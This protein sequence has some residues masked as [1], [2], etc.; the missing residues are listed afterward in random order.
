MGAIEIIKRNGEVIPLN[1]REPF[2]MVQSA[3]Q[4][5][6][7]MG[8]DNIQLT[9]VANEVLNLEK[10]DKINVFG[11]EYSIRTKASRELLSDSHYIIEATFYGVMY[12]LMKTQYRNTDIYGKST[13][14]TF[15]L[16]YSIKDFIKVLIYNVERDY[17]GLWVFDEANCP[18]TEPITLQFSK[19][20]CLQ[21]LQT[22]CKK[23]NFNLD[24]RITQTAGVRIIHIGKF[25]EVVVPPGGSA[26]FEWGK[27]AVLYK[28]KE[29]KVDDKAIIT[30]LWV[31]GGTTNI[32][33][34]YRNYSE[35]L[36]LPYPKRLN[37]YEH[38][39]E[40]GTVI[41]AN[42]QMIGIDNE[43]RRYFEDVELRDL[44]GSDE[45][46][47]QYEDIYPTRTGTITAISRDVNTFFDDTMDFDLT[48]KNEEGETKWLVAGVNA[49]INFITGKLAG[50]QFELSANEGYI[51]SEKKF[52]IIPFTDE[53]GLTIPT[54]DNE[55]FRIAPG[56]KY[57]ITDINMPDSYIDAAEE[58]LWYAGLQTFNDR[59]QP[60]AQY[61]LTLDRMYFIN[62]LPAESTYPV[63]KVG[64]YVPVRDTRFGVEKN[65][66]IQKIVR[67]LLLDHDYTL[68]LS[69]I[70]TIPIIN[71]AVIE[72]LGHRQII[73]NAR[74]KNINKI[75]GGWR[76][77]EELRNMVYD[78]DGYFDSDN[79]RP[80][81]IDTNMLTVGS[82]S[83]QFVLEDV[84]FEA[85]VN[86]LS[87]R[88]NASAGLLIHLA[89]VN[90]GVRVWSMAA[91]EFTTAE[92]GGYYLFAK[93]SKDTLNGVWH[94]STQ[95]IKFENPEDPDNYYFQVGILSSIRD[96]G[97]FRDFSTTYGYT[98]VN[99]N[100]ITTGR[101]VSSDGGCYL[102][103]D[104]NMFKIGDADS[105]IDWGV[106]V[107]GQ[108]TLKN[109]K[110]LSTSGDLS[111]IGVYRGIYYADKVYYPGDE[112]SYDNGSETCTYRYIYSTPA[113]GVNP[114]TTTHW[115][116]LA[117]GAKGD[118]GVKGDSPA[119]TYQGEYSA[120]ATYY[121]T[122]VRVD[123]VK[124]QGIYY[125]ALTT[126]GPFTGIIPTNTNYWSTMGSQFEQIATSLLLAEE[127]N[128]GGLLFRNQKLVSQNNGS[129][130][131]P[132]LT[133]DGV[134]GKIT[135][136]DGMFYG[137][138]ATPPVPIANSTAPLTLS[139]T[140]GFNFSGKLSAGSK[141][142]I[143]PYDSE[144]DGVE[145]SIINYGNITDGHYNIS[146]G[147][148]SAFL[149][150]GKY[151]SIDNVTRIHLFG[152]ARLVLKAI[153]V[154][155]Q[156]RWFVLNHNDF[157]YNYSSKVLTNTLAR[158]AMKCIGV[159]TVN[160][161]TSLVTELCTDGNT[162]TM[163]KVDEGQWKFTFATARKNTNY[164][165]VETNNN[166]PGRIQSY[167]ISKTEFYLFCGY[168]FP[169][170][171][172]EWVYLNPGTFR[173]Y[174]IEYDL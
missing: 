48:E 120:D 115:M 98:R 169:I 122:A 41:P 128:V 129:D 37:I 29:D 57:K 68:T 32:K 11:E 167:N 124:Y 150:T 143:L 117:K 67:N 49:K 91:A 69:D 21:V 112:V 154:G 146:V 125:V 172:G 144:Y 14:S 123:A 60:R 62:N 55:A 121:G 92:M 151:D 7:L 76:T 80:N 96:Y 26:F 105:W 152:C 43:D 30:R 46:S 148:G 110:L 4:T 173:F 88:F 73:E 108:L 54:K 51:H 136:R 77:T 109:V 61:Q 119:L 159:Y 127:A 171:P 44:L 50:Q 38:T 138:F 28:L 164:M 47:E 9:I 15:D 106:T 161:G 101:I 10:G 1:T 12:E 56:D 114:L 137:S 13:T 31:E 132:L 95:Q 139:F 87:G 63:F 158:P 5:I 59:K 85:N 141:Q 20:N 74:L 103:L 104:G 145:C 45:D 135:A 118:Q 94:L 149:Y 23:E 90:D 70:N 99:G 140:T 34:D 19:Q 174:L 170:P 83:Q 157:S 27:N 53:R 39:L 93:C 52:K 79:I 89:I 102:D 18:E 2:A 166:T 25:G 155:T 100:T 3:V 153:L 64:D 22:V 66:R 160:T 131:T 65:I 24:F 71:Q 16:T 107:H 156:L 116:V 130:G 163:T 134:N 81:S 168:F 35:R 84:V 33:N 97:D 72:V 162:V 147:N 40:D 126:K 8:G 142:I 6:S 78:T 111:D 82:K 133:I 58:E 17:P 86:G 36:Q 113:S 75:R 165:I 42:S